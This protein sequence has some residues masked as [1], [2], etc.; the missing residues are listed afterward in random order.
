MDRIKELELL[1]DEWN[2]VYRFEGKMIVPDSIYDQHMDELAELDPDNSR[3]T[4]VGE[5]PPDDDRKEAL[6][7]KM[8]SM[9][10]VKS[11]EE[12]ISW[13]KKNNIPNDTVF[14]I[15]PKYDAL[16]GLYDVKN[17]KGWTRGDGAIGQNSDQHFKDILEKYSKDKLESFLQAYKHAPFIY[18]T[19]EVIIPKNIFLEKHSKISLGEDGFDNGRNRVGGLFNKYKKENKS[20]LSD[21]RYMRYGF[22]CGVDMDKS[23]QLEILNQYFN[24]IEYQVPYELHTINELSSDYLKGLFDKW[25]KIFEIDGLIIEVNDKDLRNRIGFERSTKDND[26]VR[27][28]KYAR[29]YKASFEEVKDT[30]VIKVNL[31]VSKLGFIIPVAEVEPV[32]LDGAEVTNVT[33]NNAKMIY[34]LKIGKGAVIKICRSGGVIPYLIDVVKK[35]DEQFLFP[36]N[37][38]SC[39]TILVWNE[40]N[41]HL[42]CTNENCTERKIKQITSFFDILNVKGVRETTFRQLYNSGY[43]TIQKILNMSVDDFRTIDRMGD[44]KSSNVYDAIHSKIDEITLSKLQ[45]AS[46]FFSDQNTGFSLGSK[47]LLLLEKFTEKPSVS[48]VIKIDGF[49]DTSALIYCSNYNRFFEWLK[50]IP[51]SIKKEEETI[52]T[53]NNCMGKTFIFTGIRRKDLEEIIKQQGGKIVDSISKNCTHLIRKPLANGKLSNKEEKAIEYNM[54]IWSVEQLEKFLIK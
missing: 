32:M 35:S 53:S 15:T 43:D 38:P 40:T 34:D 13:M 18:T 23:S 17:S 49:S 2:K 42:M 12:L 46:G 28:P 19:G 11:F 20:A 29:A 26:E 39:N 47:K 33:C 41:T 5:T 9:N 48:D 51:V 10:K 14:C 45:H 36:T 21:I 37:C 50:T 3:L 30:T 52:I 25:V 1:L 6:P 8:A 4:K 16:S 7:L 22:H 54:N 27:N 24:D 31:D 44:T